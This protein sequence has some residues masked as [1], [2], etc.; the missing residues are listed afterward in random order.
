MRL[1]RPIQIIE[2][3]NTLL[4]VGL[5]IC[6]FA[7]V[8]KARDGRF[9]VFEMLAG[10]P[11]ILTFFFRKLIVKIYLKKSPYPGVFYSVLDKLGLTNN[12]DIDLTDD[13]LN[14]IYK[15]GY[16][17]RQFLSDN[18]LTTE[19]GTKKNQDL[20]IASIFGLMVAV[21]LFFKYKPGMNDNPA[22]LLLVLI[23]TG[24]CIYSWTAGKKSRN[25]KKRILFFSETSLEL[26]GKKLDWKDIYDWNYLPGGRNESPKIIIN[27]YDNAKNT[28]EQIILLSNL[29]IDKIDFLLLLTHFKGKY[30]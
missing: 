6:V 30:G 17:T 22:L 25:K 14:E 27:Y 15:P 21:Y 16:S 9:I 7:L 18:K 19:I 10:L 11:F 28:C 3:S 29:G 24:I 13:L 5:F 1:K 20:A 12:L 8:S 2:F 23:F 26:T 4:G